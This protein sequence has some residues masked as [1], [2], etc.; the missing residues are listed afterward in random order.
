V[1]TDIRIR[2]RR[3]IVQIQ[4]ERTSI[5][6]VIPITTEVRDVRRIAIRIVE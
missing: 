6:P 1:A 2:I 4:I 3:G 5:Q